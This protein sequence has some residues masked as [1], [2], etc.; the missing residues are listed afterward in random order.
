MA[1]STLPGIRRAAVDQ[2]SL[3]ALNNALAFTSSAAWWAAAPY[4]PLHLVSL[5]ASVGLLGVILGI[6]GVV[7][8]LVSLHVG[9]LVDQRGP[10]V[11]VKSSAI[12]FALA[13]AALTGLHNTWAVAVAFTLIGIGNIG[14]AVA[15]QAI[16]AT[17]S[18]PAARLQNFGH[19]SLWSY[20]GAVVGP[21]VGGVVAGHFGY[22]AAFVL[23]WLLM[24]PTFGIATSL[25]GLTPVS[26]PGTSLAVAH[27]HFRTIV[28]HSGVAG[29]LFISF[30]IAFGQTLQQSF[31]PVYL[32]GIGLSEMLIGLIFAAV[33]I[34]SM[35]AR[36]LVSQGV[37]WFGHASLLL[38]AMALAAISLGVT[39]LLRHFWPLVL[40]AGLMGASTGFANPTTTSLMVEP[41]AAELWGVA[42]GI[43]QG[44]QRL[45]AIVSPIA[46]GLIITDYG[47]SSGFFLGAVTLFGAVL[48]IAGVP[49]V[50]RRPRRTT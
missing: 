45:A 12:L 8:L 40:A 30:M 32:H 13:G 29:I 34:S 20:A 41:V 27:V 49:G 4:I 19:Y 24:L 22:M 36:L 38:G 18:D 17:V 15:P 25:R 44:V 5:G 1:P 11:V 35:M 26:R 2:R 6:S 28:R 3:L 9:A 48:I 39:P 21:L 47:I 14:F 16:V 43:R 23:V 7:P 37:K 50:F 10:T 33:N 42:L 31:Y 46:F